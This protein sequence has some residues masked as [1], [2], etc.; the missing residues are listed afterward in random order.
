M[1]IRRLLTLALLMGCAMMFSAARADGTVVLD[2]IGLR[3]TPAEGE[4]YITRDHM[5]AQALASLGTDSESMLA[6]M[7]REGQYLISL[8]P[9]GRQYTLA[10]SAKPDTLTCKDYGELTAAD[11]DTFLTLLAREGGYGNATWGKDG[12]AVFTSTAEAQGDG[13]LRYADLSLSTLYLNSIYTFRMDLIGR[14][15][16]QADIDLLA[17]AERRTLRLGAKTQSGQTE[18]PRHNPKRSR[19]LPSRCKASRQLFPT[20]NKAATLRWI[21]SRITSP[22]PA[23]PF[24]AKRYPAGRYGI[25]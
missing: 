14:E 8:Q 21:L 6:T 13:S 2:E 17:G 3:Y 15:A 11:K 10:V 12:Y 16:T 5:D 1:K 24:P 22:P 4:V 7:I 25:R 9:D 18:Q 19:C 20:S 23:L